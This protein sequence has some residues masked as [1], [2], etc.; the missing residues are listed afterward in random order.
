MSICKRSNQNAYKQFSNHE[1]YLVIMIFIWFGKKTGKFVF[2]FTWKKK[3]EKVL[4]KFV[5]SWLL[6]MYMFYEMVFM[7]VCWNPEHFHNI[8][9]E[10]KHITTF[11]KFVP[12]RLP[13][14]TGDHHT[15]SN[16]PSFLRNVFFAWHEKWLV[17]FLIIFLS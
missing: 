1:F 15:K 17:Q 7:S 6:F 14:A 9:F 3:K 10:Y 5:M 2:T 12:L 8:L 4:N 13:I 16:D 11:V